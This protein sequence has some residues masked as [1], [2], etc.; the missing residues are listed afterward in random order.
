MAVMTRVH[1]NYLFFCEGDLSKLTSETVGNNRKI[2]T[3]YVVSFPDLNIFAIESMGRP[4][5]E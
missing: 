1:I 5:V 3:R 4:R 2:H